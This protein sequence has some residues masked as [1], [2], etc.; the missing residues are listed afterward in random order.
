MFKNEM[1][2]KMPCWKCKNFDDG[3]CPIL[4]AFLDSV[5]MGVIGAAGANISGITFDCRE[6]GEK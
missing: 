4:E 1:T 5:P 2:E 6:Y 3:K